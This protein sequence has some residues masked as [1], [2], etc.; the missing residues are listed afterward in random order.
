M[1]GLCGLRANMGLKMKNVSVARL[2]WPAHINPRS[3][4]SSSL[5]GISATRS[6]GSPLLSR[7]PAAITMATPPPGE[8]LGPWKSPANLKINSDDPGLDPAW[9]KHS[10]SSFF[11]YTGTNWLNLNTDCGLDGWFNVFQTHQVNFVKTQTVGPPLP[12]L[13]IQY[14]WESVCLTSWVLQLVVLDPT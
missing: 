9:E 5:A 8:Q 12:E 1:P 2:E 11:L 7:L 10:V 4:G 6:P 13:M 14:G 3:Q